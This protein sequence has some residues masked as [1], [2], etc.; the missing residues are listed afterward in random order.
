MITAQ[1]YRKKPL[2]V[3][4]MQWTGENYETLVKFANYLIRT[5]GHSNTFVY[6]RLHDTWVQFEGGDWIIK[7]IQNEFYPIKDDVF[8][9]CYELEG[10]TYHGR[11][12]G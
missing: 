7:G 10:I 5:D 8:Q 3:E 12:M 9:Q 4:A 11:E 6:D 2:S 1:R